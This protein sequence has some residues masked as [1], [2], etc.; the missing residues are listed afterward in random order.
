MRPTMSRGAPR[1]S[2]LRAGWV[3]D[4]PPLG[5]SVHASVTPA[6]IGSSR[7]WPLNSTA[8][9]SAVGVKASQ[10]RCAH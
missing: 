3:G 4:T 1:P 8:V 10:T 7:P 2:L 9:P 6:R 5:R